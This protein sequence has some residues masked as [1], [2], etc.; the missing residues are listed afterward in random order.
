MTFP[1]RVQFPV[2]FPRAGDYR[3]FVQIKRN[4]RVETAAFDIAAR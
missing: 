2:V 1:P 3:L 4:D